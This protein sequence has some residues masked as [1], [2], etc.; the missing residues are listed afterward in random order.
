MI[1]FK[2]QEKCYQILNNF[3]SIAFEATIMTTIF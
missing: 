2:M 3:I 1:C